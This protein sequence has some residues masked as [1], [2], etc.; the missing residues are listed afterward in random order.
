MALNLGVPP[1]GTDKDFTPP[2]KGI[3]NCVVKS[4]E[5]V[6]NPFHEQNL[7]EG[8][9]SDPT[10][11]LWKFVVVDGE[12]KGFE[13]WYYT[14]V[15]VGRHARNKFTNLLRV[16]Y[17]NFDL[18]TNVPNSEEELRAGVYLQPLRVVASV[19]PPKEKKMDDGT[20]KQVTYGKVS[21]IWEP[22]TK[23]ER[24]ELESLIAGL[25]ATVVSESKADTFEDDIPF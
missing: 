24:A 11:L 7:A 12:H 15:S 17:P 2:P 5:E 9:K 8:K 20:T 6:P 3:Y 4:F 14:G 19:T 18:D 23:V 16:V 13:Y 10:Q 22:D 1:K 21:E 25:G